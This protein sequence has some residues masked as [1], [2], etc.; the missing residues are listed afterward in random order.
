MDIDKILA[1]IYKRKWLAYP[2][3]FILGLIFVVGF[4]SFIVPWVMIG[5][6]S[7]SDMAEYIELIWDNILYIAIG[8]AVLLI[9]EIIKSQKEIKAEK[10]KE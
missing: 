3:L 7:L 4:W 9:Y 6:W 5:A 10:E 8:V 2:F 1:F